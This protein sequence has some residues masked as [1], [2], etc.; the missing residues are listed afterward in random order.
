MSA[1]CAC[2]CGKTLTA[3]Q[4]QRKDRACKFASQECFRK[5]RAPKP[6]VCPVCGDTFVPKDPRQVHCGHRCAGAV[7][8]EQMEPSQRTALIQK[9]RQGSYA[10]YTKRIARELE[11]VVPQLESFSRTDVKRLLA[12]C[13]AKWVTRGYNTCWQQFKRGKVA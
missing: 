6:R 7:R 3:R 4:L 8:W 2:G 10:A 9:A 1:I 11:E 12:Q 5:A 13:R